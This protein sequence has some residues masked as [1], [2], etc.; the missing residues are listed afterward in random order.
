MPLQSNGLRVVPAGQLTRKWKKSW[1]SVGEN[2]EN[3][4]E[5]GMT[6][7][8]TIFLFPIRSLEG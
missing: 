5:E 7:V 4:R 8:Q 3:S 6:Y 2:P 1:D